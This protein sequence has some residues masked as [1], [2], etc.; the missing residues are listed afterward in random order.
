MSAVKNYAVLG[1]IENSIF[2]LLAWKEEKKENQSKL[3]EATRRR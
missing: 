2:I 1:Q 3:S